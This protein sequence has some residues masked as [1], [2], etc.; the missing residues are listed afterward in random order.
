M[1]LL[2]SHLP[3]RLRELFPL[4]MFIYIYVLIKFIGGG[5]DCIRF[6]LVISTF[7]EFVHS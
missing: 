4:T 7:R 5:S 2:L 1:M 6:T 3:I